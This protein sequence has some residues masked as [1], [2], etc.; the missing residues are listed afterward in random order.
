MT[1][2]VDEHQRALRT[3]AAKIEQVEAARSEEPGRVLLAESAAQ[4]RQIVQKVAN[5]NPSGFKDFGAGDDRDRIGRFE[6][7][8]ADTRARDDNGAFVSF[9]R[10]FVGGR[11]IL[12]HR[13]HCAE[14]SKSQS[15]ALH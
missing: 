4:L 13:G 7:R 8:L 5:R 1:A 10:N 3:E 11:G 12:C 9:A 2:A 14:Q 6:V 15:G